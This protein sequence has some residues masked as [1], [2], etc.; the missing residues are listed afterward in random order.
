M[1]A[2][3]INSFTYGNGKQVITNQSSGGVDAATVPLPAAALADIMNST[4]T[5]PIWV[6]KTR[7]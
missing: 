3:S 4:F 2:C 6:V 1:P 7:I 5:N